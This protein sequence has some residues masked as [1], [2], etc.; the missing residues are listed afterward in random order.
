VEDLPRG[1]ETILLVEDDHDVRALA[2]RTLED[3]GYTVLP[4]SGPHEAL[5]LAKSAR[6]DLLLTDIMMPQITGPRLVERFIAMYPTPVVVFM[7][8]HAED[9]LTAAGIN[10]T[11]EGSIASAFLRKPFTPVMLARVVREALDTQ[12]ST[13][14]ALAT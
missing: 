4:A 13:H 1:T 9:A 11:S 14:A 8:G 10:V 3:R 2:R 6:I 12:R 7:S 5:H